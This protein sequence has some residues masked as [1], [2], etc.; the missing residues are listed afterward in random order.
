MIN[1]YKWLI[2]LVILAV[3]GGAY[4]Y[5]HFYAQGINAVLAFSASYERFDKAISEFSLS[6]TDDLGR[7][8]GEA[9]GDL[10]ARSTF[11]LSSLIKNDGAL[12]DQAREVADLAR[13]EH[14]NLKAFAS[15]QR[16]PSAG[17]DGLAN[18]FGGLTEKRRSAYA[19]FRELGGTRDRT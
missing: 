15:A 10:Q 14:E 1:K 13:R 19:R 9:L 8:A 18:A 7:Q 16:T 3:A 2:T 17:L 6:R 5:L 11:R 12:M 4:F